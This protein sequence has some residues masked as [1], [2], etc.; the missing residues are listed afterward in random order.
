MIWL[1]RIIS[2]PLGIALLMSLFASLMVLRLNDTFLN[3]DFY[4]DQL[5]RA[6][7]Y[8]FVMVDV[9]TSALD[10]A[11]ALDPKKLGAGFDENPVAV[12]GPATPRIVGA[13]N[14]A[15]PPEDLEELVA[16]VALQIGEYVAA[17]RDDLQAGEHVK[18]M[19]SELKELM[20]GAGAYDLLLDQDVE[21]RIR[22]AVS[23][24]LTADENM[25]RR[26]R[27]LFGSPEDAADRLI[28]AVRRI[29]TPLW[30]QEQGE[31]ALD[32]VT[33]Y[34]VGDSDSFEIRVRLTDMQ[35][36]AAAEEIGA[37]LREGDVYEFV[38]TELIEPAVRDS[39]GKSVYLPRGIEITEDE[40]VGVLRQA[41]PPAWV[42]QQA[43]ILAD[44]GGAYVTGRTDGFSTE[45]SLVG[46]KEDGESL[47]ENLADAKLTEAV[48]GLPACRTRTEALAAADSLGHGLP[49]CIPLG[50][51]GSGIIEMVRSEVTG[52]IRTLALSLVPNRIRFT[53]SDF[54]SSVRQAGGQ[55]SLNLLDDVREL[56]REG[57][58]YGSAELRADLAGR[59]GVVEALD[60]IR[61]FLV[62]GHVYTQEYGSGDRPANPVVRDLDAAHSQAIAVRRYGWIAYVLTPVLLIGIG[63]L[64]G[65][66]WP[67]RV[68]W[69]APFLIVSA[70]TA[71]VGVGP[72]YDAYFAPMFERAHADITP[73]P[74]ADFGNTLQ[75]VA[76]KVLEV[77]ETVRGEFVG[78]VRQASLA[79]AL[80]TSAALLAALFW[81]RAA[82]AASQNPRR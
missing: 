50:S 12:Y 10:E 71:F 69:A 64:G 8:R 37:I 53:D 5:R 78:G 14:R 59:G 82:S 72:F 46:N 7:V 18:A 17:E 21:T 36:E 31:S 42:R 79:L 25:S 30:M 56:F 73:Q 33:S 11:R 65:R 61:A 58:T 34:L 3:P 54:R 6:D 19:A 23:E 62:D 74:G 75:L 81:A 70:G 66:N 55:E 67:A 22:E 24:A 49:A 51:L 77:S 1:R 4:P 68:A 9:L 20:R 40:L 43:E 27:Y 32:E 15:L 39:L 16:P 2:V 52:S 26:I 38:Y 28:Q 13:V 60:E 44:D 47:L 29:L 48:L 35:V 41:A 76:D 80:T 63:I 45:V 57:W